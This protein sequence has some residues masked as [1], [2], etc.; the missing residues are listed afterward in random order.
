MSYLAPVVEVG[1]R[2]GET[3]D[4]NGSGNGSMLKKIQVWEGDCQIKAMK[5]WLTDGRFEQFGV[6]ARNLKEF[7]F[8]SR[9]YFSSLS[10]FPNQ[11]STRLGAIKFETC[12]SREF[13]A[14]MINFT[15][16]PEVPVDVASGICMGIN[17]R[18]GLDIDRLGFMFKS[19]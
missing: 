16:Q 3:F 12:Q 6:P 11:E 1:G 9:E 7:I 5:V 2:G 13:Y 10:L 4:S 19:L 14:A 8:G 17:G 15:L 18:S